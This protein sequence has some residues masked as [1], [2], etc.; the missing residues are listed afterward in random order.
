MSAADKIFSANTTDTAAVEVTIHQ[1]VNNESKSLDTERH[2]PV[3]AEFPESDSDGIQIASANEPYIF[4]RAVSV[5]G[6]L[7]LSDKGKGKAEKVAHPAGAPRSAGD[8]PHFRHDT[9]RLNRIFADMDNR[10]RSKEFKRSRAYKKC[11]SRTL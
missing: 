10:L 5:I 3:R 8:T 9:Q 2:A 7:D 4:L 11:P 1:P 6:K